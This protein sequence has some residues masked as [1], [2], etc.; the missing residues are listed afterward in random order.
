MIPAQYRLKLSS[1][2][3]FLGTKKS[4]FWVTYVTASA[5]TP[6]WA[7]RI[8][9]RVIPLASHRNR[10]RRQINQWLYKQRESLL[11][12]SI[13]IIIMH[14]PSTPA[15]LEALQNELQPCFKQNQE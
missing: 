8:T 12:Q 15:E 5:D 13:L 10:L 4:G 14:E 11:N 1:K 3:R 6:R 2:S 7:V 9:K